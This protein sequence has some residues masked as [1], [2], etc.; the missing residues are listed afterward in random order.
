[1]FKISI[2][3]RWYDLVEKLGNY[4]LNRHW[5][6]VDI[7]KDTITS[8]DNPI[9]VKLFKSALGSTPRSFDEYFRIYSAIRETYNAEPYIK[10]MENYNFPASVDQLQAAYEKLKEY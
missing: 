6:E 9:F 5:T 4:L 7:I 3:N 1:M 10:I 2:K 8:N